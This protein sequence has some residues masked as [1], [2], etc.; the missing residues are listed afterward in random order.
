MKTKSSK[1]GTNPIA[2]KSKK[3]KEKGRI[4]NSICSSPSPLKEK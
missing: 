2:L 1:H 3:K 4:T